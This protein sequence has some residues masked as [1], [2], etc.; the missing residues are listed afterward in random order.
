MEGEQV[1]H[2]WC[3]DVVNHGYGRLGEDRD[4]GGSSV[5]R[6]DNAKRG[7]SHVRICQ[8]TSRVLG[9]DTDDTR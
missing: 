3:I 9:E 8:S 6:Q 1:N 5:R 2:S 7:W 4:G